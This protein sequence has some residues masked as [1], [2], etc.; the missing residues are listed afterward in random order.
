VPLWKTK[1][2]WMHPENNPHCMQVKRNFPRQNY[3]INPVFHR[4]LREDAPEMAYEQSSDYVKTVVHWGQRKLLMSEIE[5]LT[6]MENSVLQN[7]VVVYA[8]AAPGTH[9]PYLMNLF[10]G[11]LFVLV[12]PRRFCPTL[13]SMA[14]NCDA[15]VQIKKEFF[16]DDMATALKK[17][18]AGKRIL[19]VSDIRTADTKSQNAARIEIAVKKDMDDQMRWH[20]LLGA[21][22]SML[23]FRLQWDVPGTRYKPVT[24]YLDGDIY[25][26]VW[27]PQTTTECRLITKP[28]AG[29]VVNRRGQPTG[30]RVYNNKKYEDQLFYHNRVLR[31]S[32]YDHPLGDAEG[33]DHCYDCRAEIEILYNYLWSR[34]HGSRDIWNRISHM[35]KDI[36]KELDRSRTLES[37][38]CDNDD[39]PAPLRS[40][41]GTTIE[42]VDC[43]SSGARIAEVAC[44]RDGFGQATQSVSAS[45]SVLADLETRIAE[46]EMAGFE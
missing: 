3:E 26:P 9:I 21:Y 42:D 20:Q 31:P 11:V 15:T 29:Q 12:D 30:L 28:G 16:T 38:V 32:L 19:F 35:S 37:A 44:E 46:L 23:K 6:L 24:K 2:E 10:P 39:E 41:P 33:I 22:R 45:M 40:G 27:G 17:Q 43:Q 1:E 36:S 18:Y 14:R 5:F 7:A 25:L 4:I 13:T 34:Q 8:G